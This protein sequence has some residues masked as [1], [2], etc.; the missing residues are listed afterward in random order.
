VNY[1]KQSTVARV[2]GFDEE[3]KEEIEIHLFGHPKFSKL[4]CGYK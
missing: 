1:L 2:T 4:V 3:V